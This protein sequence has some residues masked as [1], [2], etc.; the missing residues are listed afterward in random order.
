MKDKMELDVWSGDWGLPSVDFSCL[1]MMLYCRFSGVPIKFNYTN[2]PW[3]SST[4]TLPVFKQS[5]HR[6]SKFQDIVSHLKSQNYS[7]DLNL[8]AKESGDI[9]AY[10]ALLKEQLEPAIYYLFWIDERNYNSIIRPWYGEKLG[11]PFNYFIP[12]RIKKEAE[13]FIKNRFGIQVNN[14]ETIQII[15]TA[16]HS[17]AQKCLTL[18]SERLNNNEFFFGKNPSSFDAIVF[19]YLAPLLKT[20]FINNSLQNHLKACDNLSRFV[21]RILQKYFPISK[22]NSEQNKTQNNENE[23]K[24]S[25]YEDDDFPH[26]WRDIILSTLFAATAMLGYA[27]SVGLIQIEIE[28]S[29]ESQPN[30][31]VP[32]LR[33]ILNIEDNE[34][35]YEESKSKDEN[36]T[37]SQNKEQSN[38]K[39]E[40]Q[41]EQQGEILKENN[42]NKSQHNEKANENEH[43]EK[44]N[45][46]EHNE[47]ANENELS[48]NQYNESKEPGNLK[49]NNSNK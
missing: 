39:S 11:F 38:E 4:G 37:E 12:N 23:K 21:N 42:G 15:E 34:D 32:D 40:E 45:E 7:A 48:D 43:N 17:E 44:A 6:L 29:D 9:N 5:N 33:S 18:L 3:W 36:F 31:T 22:D 35:D 27:F 30:L 41:G 47:K 14:I 8:S 28:D 20:P 10:S 1:Q 46:N 2:N 19:G 49:E 16:V 13:K 25:T 26:K 24:T